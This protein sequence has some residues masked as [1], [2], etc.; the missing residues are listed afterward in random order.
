MIFEHLDKYGHEQVVFCHNKDTGLKAII[1][2]H[3]TVLGPALGGTRMWPYKSEQEALNDVLRLSRGMTYKNAVAGLN[4]G[5]G[6]AV[7]IGDPAS[8]KSE[9]LFRSFGQFVESLG[10]RYITAEDVGI[11]VNDMEFVYR[12]TEYVTGVHQV[13]GGSGDPSPFTAY[14]TLQGLM[15][16]LN[17]KFGDE[18]VGKYSYAVQGLGHVGIEFVKLLKERGAKIFVTDINKDRVDRAVSEYGAEAVGLDEIYDVDADVYSPCALGGTVNEET[19]PRLKA[20]I[21]CGAANNQLATNEI[22]DEVEKRGMLYAPDYAVNA[23]GVMNVSLEID[24]YNRERA[25]RM[26]RTI[27]HNLTRIFEIS[28]RDGIPT[29]MAADRL[30]EERIQIIGKL[31]LPLGRAAPRFQGRVR[32]H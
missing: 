20:K 12:E 5:G 4:I 2:I 7:I 8:D 26:M 17:K 3:N 25:M 1:A 30:A 15:A 21:I 18:E 19:L 10:G 6:K 11:D 31:K 27:Y 29:Y 16:S 22:G 23:G 24:G 9:A 32:G 13:H 28:E 14:G